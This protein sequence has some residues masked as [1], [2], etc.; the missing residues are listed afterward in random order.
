M[1][2]EIKKPNSADGI[3]HKQSL[4]DVKSCNSFPGDSMSIQNYSV[5]EVPCRKL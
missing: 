4:R 5:L 3:R 1:S 2:H